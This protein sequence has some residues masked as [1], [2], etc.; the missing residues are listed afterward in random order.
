MLA[1]YTSHFYIQS[2]VENT[3]KLNCERRFPH[4]F[5]FTEIN[6]MYDRKSPSI[7]SFILLPFPEKR[8]FSK[9]VKP[10][11]LSSCCIEAIFI[12]THIIKVPIS[13]LWRCFFLYLWPACYTNCARSSRFYIRV[14]LMK[15][16]LKTIWGGFISAVYLKSPRTF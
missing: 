10:V 5:C 9:T 12:F 2:F 16:P 4:G 8:I 7:V 3:L 14:F 13:S 11:F 1:G 6:R 15:H